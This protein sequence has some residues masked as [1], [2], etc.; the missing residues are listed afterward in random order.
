M[1]QQIGR[2]QILEE[3]ASGGQGTVY[4]VFDPNTGQIVALKVLH[5]TLSG[6]RTYIERF[7]REASLAAS[8]DHPNVVK[9]FV[10]GQDGDRHFIALEFLP[11]SL[12]GIIEGVGQLR[13]E[14]AAQYGVQ[15]ADG[16]A[17]AHALGIV[18][19]DVK[20]Q[21]VLIGQDGTAKVTDFGIA[22]SESLATMTATGAVMGTPHYM[23]PEQAQGERA[24]AR[25]DV[26]S[27]G[28]MVYQMLAGEVPF[29]GDTPLS[30]IMQQVNDQPRGL[31]DLRSDLPR[32]LEAVVDRSMA[33]DPESRFQSVSDL[34]AALRDALPEVGR[35][36]VG[37]TIAPPVTPPQPVEPQSKPVE[38]ESDEVAFPDENLEAVVRKA[39]G[40]PRRS[41]TRGD[42]QMLKKLD[43]EA[44]NIGD[45][46]GLEHAVNLT[47]L[48]LQD[49]HISDIS[50]LA[51]LAN[52][53]YLELEDN[54]ISD[55]S[56]LA[57]LANLTYLELEDNQISDILPLASLANLTSLKL[58]DNQIS[59]MSPLASLTNLAWLQLG[60]NQINDISPL[61]SL[62]NLTSLFLGRNQISNISPL[63]SLTNLTN[64]G[65]D[66]NQISDISP[67][68]SLTNLIELYLFG[69]QIK[70][71]WLGRNADASA[72]KSRGVNVYM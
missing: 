9:I 63:A 26:Y 1:D 16:L 30:V 7:R 6:D 56:P 5:P 45:L 18:H 67:L 23:S 58:E 39:L 35:P 11:E 62:A 36:R 66:D 61:A 2:Y 34:S 12:A 46:T 13:I 60:D 28:C 57:S 4:R 32:Q 70:T 25:S 27:L 44:K 10:V 55:I 59:D 43:G 15:I 8:I 69:N 64:L 48:Y 37:P 31:R 21:N 72:L 51:S 3:I 20:P 33:K 68:A 22:R 29:K 52:L 71:N 54:Q 53:T 17:A 19:R 42:L 49:N 47:E 50:P 40:E 38:N 24:D 41:L 65:L 14:G